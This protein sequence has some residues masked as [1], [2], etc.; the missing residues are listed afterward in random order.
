MIETRKYENV[1]Q[2]GYQPIHFASLKGHYD[3]VKLLTGLPGKVIRHQALVVFQLCRIN[4]REIKSYLEHSS[5]NSHTP[6][7]PLH[8]GK[9]I[10]NCQIKNYQV[11][12]MFNYCSAS[13]NGN[14]K[15]LKLLVQ[16]YEDLV[17]SQTADGSTVLHLGNVVRTMQH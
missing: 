1:Y 11:L 9:N 7:N 15:A 3:I 17:Y 13:W 12:L 2:N 8:L 14:L 5:L 16:K 4:P 6:A 10:F